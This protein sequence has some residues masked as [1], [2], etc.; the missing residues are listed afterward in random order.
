MGITLTSLRENRRTVQI[1]F[2]EITFNVT[3]R[4]G[5]ITPDF[6]AAEK[7]D[8]TKPWLV[9]MLLRLIDTWDIFED[10]AQTVRVPI[11]A[12]ML[13]SEAFGV[14][15]LRVMYDAILDDAFLPKASRA[16]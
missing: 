12:E 11:T 7:A 10:D 8:K 14:P 16:S 15:L 5:S 4:P 6:G 9:D 13:G 3:Y 1:Q 2:D